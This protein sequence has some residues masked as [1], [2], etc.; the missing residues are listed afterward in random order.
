MFIL[1]QLFRIEGERLGACFLVLGMMSGG[2]WFLGT[3]SI[4]PDPGRPIRL[5]DRIVYWLGYTGTEPV[6]G[7]W[8]L[9]RTTMLRSQRSDETVPLPVAIH[10]E[11]PGR[12]PLA[13]SQAITLE[14]DGTAVELTTSQSTVGA[15]LAEAQI[16]IGPLDRVEPALEAAIA[17]GLIVRIHRVQQDIRTSEQT[18]PYQTLW[19]GDDNLPLDRQEVRVE[20]TQGQART[21]TL[22]V[23]QD[24]QETAELHTESWL[25]KAPV[26]RQI[27][28]GKRITR[29][30][31][32][33]PDGSTVAYWRKIRMFATSYSADRA[34][35]SADAPWYG[36]TYSGHRMRNGVVAMHTWLPLCTPIYVPHYGQGQVLD[37]GSGLG[38]YDIDLGYSDTDWRT[39]SRWVDV[40]LLWPPP[41]DP[42]KITWV[43]PTPG[44]AWYG[45][46]DNLDCV[47]G[48]LRSKTEPCQCAPA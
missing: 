39:W 9:S 21:R 44:T 10:Q 23:Y 24:G 38:V 26:H 41:A 12:L 5:P 43:L 14:I 3:Q 4:V 29:A 40:Y 35:I 48:R 30:E 20:G 8:L 19:T 37:R 7:A 34:G 1:R 32:T 16:G 36:F 2:L 11:A 25:V 42:A 31:F 22:V 45:T 17:T 15:A 28:F 46:N 13:G 47:S 18:V 6:H 27:A 33:G